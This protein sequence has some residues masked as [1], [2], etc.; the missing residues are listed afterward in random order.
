M[1]L[2]HRFCS[3]TGDV[4][5]DVELL[6]GPSRSP[7]LTPSRASPLKLRLLLFCHMGCDLGC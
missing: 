3:V 5:W 6:S 1:S 7:S 2:L 4:I